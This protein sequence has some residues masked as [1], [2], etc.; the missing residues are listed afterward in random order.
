MI[1]IIGE[2]LGFDSENIKAEDMLVSDMAADSLAI[3]KIIVNMEDCFDCTLDDESLYSF[4][5]I[6]VNDFCALV[7]NLLD[8]CGESV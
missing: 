8:G 3:A 4:D 7:E 5:D 2:T 1:E 6:S